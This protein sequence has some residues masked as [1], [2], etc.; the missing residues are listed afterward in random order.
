MK[1]QSASINTSGN[2]EVRSNP[3]GWEKTGKLLVRFSVPTIVSIL[4]SSLYNVVDQIFIGQG[5]G[6]LG[7][8]A[9]TVSF[10][11]TTIGL[12]LALLLG[13]GASASYSL[14]L[15]RGQLED[16]A[17]TVGC[18]LSFM[19]IIG[20]VYFVVG[21]LLLTFLLPVFGATADNYSYALEYSRIILIGMPFLIVS[22]GLCNLCQADG[23]PAFSMLC[24]VTGA[25]L[26]CI[27]DP[28]FIFVFGWGM[29]GAALAT[30]IG[31]MLSLFMLLFYLPRFKNVSLHRHDFRLSQTIL[32]R[33]CRLGAAASL[34][35]AAILV[36]Q[37]VLNNLLRSYGAQSIYGPDIPIAA[38]GVAFKL[39]GIFISVMVGL[40]Q[41]ARPIVGFNYGARQYDRVKRVV[42][43][44]MATVIVM[45]TLVEL[46][47][48]L[49]PRELILLFGHG[50][51]L[52]I[53][54]GVNMLRIYLACICLIGVQAL[55]SNY[56]AAIAQPGK[57]AFL[58]LSRQIIFYIPLALILTGLFG[59][60]GILYSQPAADL[61]SV[62]VSILMVRLSF[63]QM[64]RM[65]ADEAKASQ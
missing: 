39:N 1:E 51:E 47:F 28:L 2:D 63:R 23:S 26:N 58:S 40:S 29:Q 41:G 18:S 11:L 42:L 46:C 14:Q 5:V 9:T 54:F 48:Q 17:K 45:G 4:V 22:N 53:Q 3:L 33:T 38:S 15:G 36:V 59:I 30:I 55:A 57:G 49:F 16:A 25:V 62:V 61:L 60:D 44:A 35:Q 43:Q 37:I 10:P 64:D 21:E 32:G 12:A 27:L 65:K 34:N 24:M 56:F 7:N 19:L 13:V 6:F 50:D 20:V 31:Q 8:G 52:Y